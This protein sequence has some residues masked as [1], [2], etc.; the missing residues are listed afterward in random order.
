MLKR[1]TDKNSAIVLVNK[2]ASAQVGAQ[3]SKYQVSSICKAPIFRTFINFSLPRNTPKDTH[4]PRKPH[5]S[6]TG[7]PKNIHFS[8]MKFFHFFQKSLIEV[9]EDLSAGKTTFSQAEISYESGRVPFDQLKVSRD[10]AQSRK[11]LNQSMIK[12]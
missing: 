2:P 6:A 9:K 7:N 3:V 8:K 12:Y 1:D 4:K 5:F 10:D 11:K